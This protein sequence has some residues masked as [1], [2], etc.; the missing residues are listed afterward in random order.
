M[1]RVILYEH[2]DFRGGAVVL[3]PGESIDNFSGRTFDNGAK[4]NDS[5][6]SI[7]V[8]GDVE[9][10]IYEHSRYRGDALRLGESVRDLTGRLVSGGVNASW[11]DRISS[12]RVVAVRGGWNR[13]RDPGRPNDGPRVFDP[14]KA[15][16]SVFKDV[17]NR[18]PD[19]GELR[20]FANRMR[21]GGWTERML[22]DF[23]R[24]EERYRLEVADR[25]VR[26]AYLDV[27]GREADEGG[28]RTYRRRMLND[29]WTEGDV[30]DDLRKSAE[31]R[32]KHR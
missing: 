8:E 6:S 22:R 18:E 27:L 15:V 25:L 13:D 14:E 12:I 10:Y 9:V 7:R 29:N 17:L 19:P 24:T 20:D 11:N 21:D 30:R 26:R 31:Y 2:A 23:L 5:V 32:S 28:L 1:A 3:Y 16:K 4:L